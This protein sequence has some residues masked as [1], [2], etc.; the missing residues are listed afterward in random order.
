MPE[1]NQIIKNNQRILI[2]LILQIFHGQTDR[3]TDR[4]TDRQTF[5]LILIDKKNKTYQNI[6]NKKMK[7]NSLNKINQK[8]RQNL[9]CPQ[10]E[11]YGPSLFE[12]SRSCYY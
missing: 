9:G 12:H 6:I 10:T 2:F 3:Q 5:A 11:S 4:P 8:L 1:I 7:K